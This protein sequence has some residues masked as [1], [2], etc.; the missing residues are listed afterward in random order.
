[1]NIITHDTGFLRKKARPVEKITDQEKQLFEDM[2]ATMYSKK[3]VG[4]AA[5]QVGVLKQLIVVDVGSGPLRLVNP[6]IT[7]KVKERS[8]MEE[9]CL[10]FPGIN[11][12]VRRSQHITVE[13][14]DCSGAPVK[15]QAR[16]MM[17][18]A[19]QHEIDHLQGRLIIDYLPWFKRTLVYGKLRKNLS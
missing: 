3:G 15:I 2:L 11:V 17:A 19:L 18:R 10:S 14:L 13:A 9:G 7:S 16:S 1:V 6:R 5:P 12:K 8:C 4:L